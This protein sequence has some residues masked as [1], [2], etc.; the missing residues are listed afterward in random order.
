MN[1][2]QLWLAMERLAEGW[3]R[4]LTIT[5]GDAQLIMREIRA[6]QRIIREMGTCEAL[7]VHD[8]RESLGV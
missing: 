3:S 5:V 8:V 7:L 2:K 1:E 6:L 4:D